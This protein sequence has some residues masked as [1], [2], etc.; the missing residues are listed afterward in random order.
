MTG[1]HGAAVKLRFGFIT[2]VIEGDISV[3]ERTDAAD[4]EIV[5]RT[6]SHEL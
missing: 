5:I 3:P 4:C 6:V 1:V 2:R